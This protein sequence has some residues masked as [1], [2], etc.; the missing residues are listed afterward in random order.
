MDH[1]IQKGCIPLETTINKKYVPLGCTLLSP[2]VLIYTL[3]HTACWK[4]MPLFPNGAAQVCEHLQKPLQHCLSTWMKEQSSSVTYYI[5]SS[6]NIT[7]LYHR[8]HT[9]WPACLSKEGKV[10]AQCL[11]LLCT[12][13]GSF[14]TW[15]FLLMLLL[16]ACCRHHR[17][18]CLFLFLACDRLTLFPL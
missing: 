1:W 14:C 5:N 8:Y 11:E 15:L 17:N 18:G 3:S 9:L 7:V 10:D 6:Q 4:T 13:N 12:R 2:T 16:A